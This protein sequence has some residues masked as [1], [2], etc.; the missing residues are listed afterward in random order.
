MNWRLTLGLP[1][2]LVAAC[3]PSQGAEDVAEIVLA[4][5]ADTVL[6][7]FGQVPL[8]APMGGDRWLVVAPDWDQAVIADF[9]T[10]GTTPL[11][12]GP[13]RD[14]QRPVNVFASGDSLYLADWGMRRLT[15][16]DRAGRLGRSAAPPEA[17]RGIFPAA[18]DGAGQFYF[19]TPLS[20]GPDGRGLMDSAPVLRSDA[21][22]ERFDT[23]AWLGPPDVLEVVREGRSRLERTVFGGRDRWGVMPDGSL[24]VARVERSRVEWTDP[25]GA[26]RRGPSLPDPVY[27]VT[28]FDREAF[29]AQFPP[30]LRSTA[31]G[32]PFALVK[33]PFEGAFTGPDRLVWL[34]KSRAGADSVR[35]VHAVG[36]D[37]NLVRRLVVPTRGRLIAVGDSALLIAEQWREGVRLLQVKVPREP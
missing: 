28:E 24:W 19:E 5:P 37:G 36:A 23:V 21:R 4:A 26:T 25:S 10:G 3:G 2:L 13:G 30:D 29:Y 6:T 27:E 31:E 8:A 18:R 17:L 22:M 1:G 15:T 35:R 34:E 16:W 7:P 32:L 11:G 9:G 33:P 14:Y 12:A 20:G